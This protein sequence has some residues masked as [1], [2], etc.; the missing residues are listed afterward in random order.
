MSKEI[1]SKGSG[2]CFN[3]KIVSTHNNSQ[4]IWE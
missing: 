1:G 3:Q 2:A 4:N